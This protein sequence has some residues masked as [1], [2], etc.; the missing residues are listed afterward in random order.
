MP[1]FCVRA[2]VR[3]YSRR[4]HITPNTLPHPIPAPTP[5][6]WGTLCLVPAWLLIKLLFSELYL[7]ITYPTSTHPNSGRIPQ[8]VVVVTPVTEDW[9]WTSD[10]VV[11]CVD[12]GIGGDVLVVERLEL[13]AHTCRWVI[14]CSVADGCYSGEAVV[15]LALFTPTL[16]P[17]TP[18]TPSAATHPQ[19][20]HPDPWWMVL[21]Q[22]PT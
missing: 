6:R 7:V 3:R 8:T 20:P 16:P 1:R 10:V 15:T 21:G 14:T 13:P 9:W 12:S 4:K 5:P 19:H 18:Y 22:E 17:A 2:C 11:C